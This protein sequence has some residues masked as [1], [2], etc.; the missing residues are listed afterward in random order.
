MA[1]SACI[2]CRCPW[3]GGNSAQ[4]QVPGPGL[5]CQQPSSSV[6][7]T[8]AF[9]SSHTS[10]PTIAPGSD[11]RQALST[12]LARG[13]I[14]QSCVR[15]MT[16]HLNVMTR[17]LSN[18]RAWLARHI[19][20]K[21]VRAAQQQDLRSRSAFKL[22]QIDDKYKLLKGNAVVVD[23]GSSPGGW[24][25]AAS[26]VM[27]EQ[28]KETDNEPRILAVDLLPMEPVTGV[29]FVQGDF[30]ATSVQ[31]KIRSFVGKRVGARSKVLVLSDMLQNT[32][33]NGDLDHLRSMDLMQTLLDFVPDLVS[34]ASLS[35][36]TL[37]AKYYQGRDE[38]EMQADYRRC[39]S[40]V[41]VVKPEASRKESR[42]MYLYS[43]QWIGTSPVAVGGA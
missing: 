29:H 16:S 31:E 12:N 6:P 28:H 11:S 17:Q 3:W 10:A 23:L 5:A 39:F 38:K 1:C 37:L 13:M 7:D 43:T 40:V 20:D 35:S 34:S 2:Q 4:Q 24:S 26:R 32:T 19:G 42:E 15:R 27:S 18:S 22:L 9:T 36:L 8:A 30:T 25:V 33:G 41:K 14:R 21:Y